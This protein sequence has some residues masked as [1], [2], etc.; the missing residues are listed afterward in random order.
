MKSFVPVYVNISFL[1]FFCIF[2]YSKEI[3]HTS[4]KNFQI[5]SI[6]ILVGGIA[7]E[8]EE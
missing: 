4:I 8:K 6:S 1:F 7:R 5:S 3:Y 2:N